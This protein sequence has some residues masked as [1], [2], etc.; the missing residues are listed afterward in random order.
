M[1]YYKNVKITLTNGKVSV[2]NIFGTTKSIKN[3]YTIGGSIYGCGIIKSVDVCVN[4]N[5]IK[6]GQYTITNKESK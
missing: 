3:R 4:K 1:K 2:T 5:M 6:N